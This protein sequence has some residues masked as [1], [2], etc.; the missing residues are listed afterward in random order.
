MAPAKNKKQTTVTVRKTT[1]P[2]N[3]AN[4]KEKGKQTET[5]NQKQMMAMAA[6]MAPAN[7]HLCEE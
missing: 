3:P 2:V 4:G 1:P 5:R 7:T 6:N